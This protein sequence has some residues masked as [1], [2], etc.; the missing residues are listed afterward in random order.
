V[1]RTWTLNEASHD[2]PA[3]VDRAGSEGVQVLLRDG[4]PAASVISI[5]DFEA[6][7][8]QKT[9]MGDFLRDLPWRGMEIDFERDR[10]SARDVEF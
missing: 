3:L 6:L 8:N 10:G 2:L 5:N 1:N 4:K 7:K 9:P